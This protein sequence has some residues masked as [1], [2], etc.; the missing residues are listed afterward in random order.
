MRTLIASV[1]L[2]VA[3]CLAGEKIGVQQ[4]ATAGP[5]AFG[6]FAPQT[7]AERELE[8]M[9]RGKDDDIDLALANW[10]VVADVP[11]FRD[12]A[13]D[14]YLKQLNEMTQQV[15][16]SMARMEAV[17][18]SRG[19]NPKDPDTRCA[20]FANAIIKLR[21]EYADEFR[22]ENLTPAR[23]NAMYSDANNLFLT[24]LLLTRRGSCMSMPLIYLVIGLR[25][26]M[27]VH[28][29]TVGRHSFI[30]WEEPG[31]R[32]NIETTSVDKVRVTPDDTVFT[33]AETLKPSELVGNQMRNLT[34]REVLG[35]LFYARS[36]HWGTQGGKFKTQQILDLATARHLAPDDPAIKATHEAV[37]KLYGIKPEHTKIEI[38]IPPKP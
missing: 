37:F 38:R 5:S 9:V 30:R 1:I 11:Q 16:E 23:M 32:M 24:G 19:Q 27:P 28:L 14:V 35:N 7:D 8:K 36:A 21:F 25:L 4:H 33:D 3:A 34:R 20:I 17:A 13:R 2:V 29:V 6:Q 15:R 26:D 18:R 31:Y 22:Y 12:F 10:L